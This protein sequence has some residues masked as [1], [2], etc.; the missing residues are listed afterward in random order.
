[1]VENCH[2]GSR[3]PFEPNATWCP[4]NFYRTS[5]D[6]RANYASVV[7]NLN[8]VFKFTSRNLSYPGCWAYPDMVGAPTRRRAGGRKGRGAGRAGGRG[9]RES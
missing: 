9:G 2:W 8:S 3:K 7:G 6:V 5:G 4:W 1:M